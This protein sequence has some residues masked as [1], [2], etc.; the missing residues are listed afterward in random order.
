M[1]LIGV[2][3]YSKA[4]TDAPHVAMAD[5]AVCIGPA[6]AGDSYLRIDR[7][8][9]AARETGANAVHPGYGFLAENAAFASA[10]GEA[11]IVF[12]GPSPRAIG[13]MGDKAA[14]RRLMIAAGVPC[15]PGYEGEDQSEAALTAAAHTIGFPLMVKAA[16][17]GGGRGMRVVSDGGDLAR[18]IEQARSEAERA[19]GSGE[20]ILE[21]AIF[22]PRHVEFQVIADATGRTVHLG[23]RDCSIQRRHQ[24]VIEEAPC[25]VMTPA[26]RQRMGDTAVKAA[27]SI[28]YQGAGT[29]EFLLDTEQ[30]FY[31]LEMNT[32]LQVEHP[33]TELVTGVDLVASQIRIARGEPLELDQAAI[34]MQ[35]H[36]IE[37]R[38]YTEDPGRDFV[39]TTGTVELWQPAPGDGVRVDDG[40]RS[41]QEISPYYDAMAAKLIAWGATREVARH[42]LTAALR[43]AV[44]FGPRTNKA[45]LIQCL[46]HERFARGE[47]TTAF[48]REEM[49]TGLLEGTVA[50]ARDA[51]VAGVLCLRLDRAAAMRAGAGVDPGLLNWSSG[52]RS[53]AYYRL[54]SGGEAFDVSIL[55]GVDERYT[56]RVGER[57][58]ALRIDSLDAEGARI[59]VDEALVTVTCRHRTGGRLWLAIAGADHL[60]VR[61]VDAPSA[62]D[63]A[64]GGGRVTA[65]MHGLIQAPV[66]AAGVHVEQGQRL[67][68]MEAM[69]MQQEVVSPVTG[70]VE[71]VHVRAGQQVATGDLLLTI[72]EAV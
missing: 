9:R 2:A 70:R 17:G 28:H 69:K 4:D 27:E 32:R 8:L 26:L 25:P 1:G 50:T 66:V 39:P 20:L 72:E 14:A 48:I 54:G 15:V 49:E 56:A 68:V 52:I 30:N 61:A 65:T 21:K 35:G 57:E 44:L 37:A 45:F 13:L 29:V 23:E 46:Q 33:V 55:G 63:G 31:F 58:Y 6:P 59:W 64:S 60:F 12:I 43:D 22:R 47:T 19:F 51:V 36:A 40:I 42:R 16:A 24:K 53:A 11:G 18:A 41:G 5:L 67:L 7:I 38:L 10:C 34:R 3:V 71:T 62:I